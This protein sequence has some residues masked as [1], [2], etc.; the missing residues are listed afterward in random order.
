MLH[1]PAGQE[2]P[3]LLYIAD[4]LGKRDD[5]QRV[6]LLLEELFQAHE[7]RKGDTRL[8]LTAL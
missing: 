7:P 5:R 8:T 6:L 1:L 4:E 2:M 3:G